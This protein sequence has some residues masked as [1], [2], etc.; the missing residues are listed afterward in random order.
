MRV[1]LLIFFIWLNA[2]FP[3]ASEC[4]CDPNADLSIRQLIDA[5]LIFKGHVITKRTEL[6][7]ELG[8]R[9]VATFSID[10]LISGNPESST[11]DIEF[12]YGDDFCSIDFQ[13][14]FSY[15]IIANKAEDFPFYQTHYCSGNKRWENLTKN[16]LDLLNDFQ[17]GKSDLEWKDK[18]DRV[19]AKGMLSQRRP[20]GPW[21]FFVY[22]GHLSES[23]FYQNGKKEGDWYTFYHQFTVCSEL[24]LPFVNGLCD[25][26]EV[27]QPNPAGWVSSVIPYKNG[28]IHGSV[29]TYKASGCID[30]EANYENGTLMGELITY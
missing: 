28:K 9:Y 23:G 3:N 30:S 15:F 17:N 20:T 12:G 5:D 26:A 29:L 14:L 21:Q 24:N 2:S 22:D 10:E 8:Y 16:D 18:F 11:V 6:F 25:L 4:G 7:P 13:P 1:F 27:A 19:Y